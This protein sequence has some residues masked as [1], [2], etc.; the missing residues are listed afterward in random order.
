[1]EHLREMSLIFSKNLKYSAKSE[2]RKHV[3]H[4]ICDGLHDLVSFL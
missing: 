3:D 2:Y 4:H 1:M